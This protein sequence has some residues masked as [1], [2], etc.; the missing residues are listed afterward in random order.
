MKRRDFLRVAAGAVAASALSGRATAAANT[1]P[2][3]TPLGKPLAR[4]SADIAASPLSVGFEV[5][6]REGFDPER[7]YPHLKALG[8]KWARCQTG[9]CR[10][11]T[12]KGEYDFAWLDRIVDSLRA[13]GIR[14]WFNLGYGNRLYMPDAPDDAA[15]GWAPVCTPGSMEPWLRYTGALAKHFAGRVT[16]WEIW[17]E[18]NIKHFWAPLDPNA[19]DY[20]ELVRQTA[21]VVRA[22]V[23]EA[24]IVGGAY[25]GVPKDYMKAAFEAGMAEFVDAM[26]YHPY[27]AVP[28][29]GY[30]D[31]VAY[32]RGL[33]QEYKPSLQLWQGENGCP[34]VT[35]QDSVGALSTLEWDE[36]RQAKWLLRRI[37]TDRH[38]GI[39]LTSYF[40]TVDLVGY[41]GKTNFKGLLRGADYT[42]KPSYHAYQ[43]LCA[44]FDGDTQPAP[45][46]AAVD[47]PKHEST[48]QAQFA[49]KS[50]LLYAYWHPSD[51]QKGFTSADITVRVP[52]GAVAEPVL[53]DLI[54]QQTYALA[55]PEPD[56]G[57]MCAWTLPLRDYPVFIAERAAAT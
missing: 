16:H 5:L 45:L 40:H 42:P 9:W 53:I 28:E 8:V 17:N 31:D 34:S 21:P 14:P 32:M 55:K 43:G 36:T 11:E 44:L 41:R 20:V 49:R 10:C 7:A 24:F 50:G 25:A 30:D 46:T 26:S 29:K 6:D 19:A 33:V 38:F 47:A 54:E 56:A 3:L 51:L 39:D 4:A 12:V 18:P 57:G 13:I 15:V 35:G 22:H 23:P 52:P 27:R 48:R 1:A 2:A 37:V